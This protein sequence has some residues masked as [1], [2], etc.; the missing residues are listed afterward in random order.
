MLL[1]CGNGLSRD[2]L[3][4][5]QHGMV[6]LAGDVSLYAA[7]DFG[8]RPAFSHAAGEVVAGGLVAAESDNADDVQ[9]AVGVA[10]SASVESVTHVFAPTKPSPEA[11]GN[12]GG[13]LI[14]VQKALTAS[15]RVRL[16]RRGG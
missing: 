13:S 4:C 7:H 12:A 14:A 5:R 8:F 1:R 11:E 15:F 3:A 2:F 16:S 10:V 6:D 9:S